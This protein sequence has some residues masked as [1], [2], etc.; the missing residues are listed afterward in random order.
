MEVLP[1]CTAD[2]AS[3]YGS[4]F[5]PDEEGILNDLLQEPPTSEVVDNPIASP[6]LRLEDAEAD[7]GLH[8]IK[9]SL[10]TP[11]SRYSSKVE[12][13]SD[14]ALQQSSAQPERPRV[15]STNGK[16]SSPI[17]LRSLTDSKAHSRV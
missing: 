14:E 12:L 2:E 15:L 10:G 7:E 5:T 13:A 16:T 1:A 3:E 4:D 11:H 9:L 8:G 17:P 6:E